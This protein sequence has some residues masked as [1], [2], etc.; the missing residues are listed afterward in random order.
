MEANDGAA[1]FGDGVDE[2]A[3]GVEGE[4]SGTGA[5]G[6]GDGGGDRWG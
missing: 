5:G 2:F 3:V 6:D 4:V 1:H